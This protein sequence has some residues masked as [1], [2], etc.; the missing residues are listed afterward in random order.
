MLATLRSLAP[1]EP[2]SVAVT[3]AARD[4]A[5]GTVIAPRDTTVTVLPDGAAP[6]GAVADPVGETLAA[7]VR[8]GEA[9]T[10]VRLA[11]QSAGRAVDGLVASPVRLPDADAV[12]LLRPGDRIDL[13]ATDARRGRT[14][15]VAVGALVLAV[16]EA[17]DAVTG[18]LGGRI[19]VLGLPPAAVEQVQGAA[20]AMFLSYAYSD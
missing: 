1:P 13:V 6:D 9:V 2:P 14:T 20:V 12:A 4:L 8:R 19:V 11:G 17:G 16:P 7:P 3:V 18:P 10:D 15:T 5:A